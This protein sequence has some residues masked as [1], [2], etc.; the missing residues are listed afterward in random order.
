M[1][2]MS[3]RFRSESTT[4]LRLSKICPRAKLMVTTNS[5]MIVMTSPIWLAKRQR[6]FDGESV[7]VLGPTAHPGLPLKV[8]LGVGRY[9]RL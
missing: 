7:G 8:F 4:N 5:L 2:R 9:R 1:S 3:S 6:L